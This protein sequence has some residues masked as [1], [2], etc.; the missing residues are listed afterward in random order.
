[1]A[2]MNFHP[3]RVFKVKIIYQKFSVAQF[4]RFADRLFIAFEFF[5]QNDLFACRSDIRLIS[6]QSKSSG[7][8]ETIS[9]KSNLEELRSKKDNEYK[10]QSISEFYDPRS[11]H[12]QL[13]QQTRFRR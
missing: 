2:R 4:A 13:P 8:I 11:H 10:F 5:V 7:F 6:R 3:Q 1:M 9:S 12:L